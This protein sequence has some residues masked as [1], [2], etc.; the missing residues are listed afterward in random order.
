MLPDHSTLSASCRSL[1]FPH[2]G[3]SYLERVHSAETSRSCNWKIRFWNS[4]SLVLRAC[5]FVSMCCRCLIPCVRFVRRTGGSAT[6]FY[7]RNLFLLVLAASAWPNGHGPNSIYSY[8]WWSS[9]RADNPP[10]TLKLTDDAPTRTLFLLFA[11]T[12][13]RQATQRL[14][15]HHPTSKRSPS[16]QFLVLKTDE[17]ASRQVLS[18]MWPN[19]GRGAVTQ[20][21]GREILGFEQDDLHQTHCA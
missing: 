21:Y 10:A 8:G 2:R 13:G 14:V 16:M 1:S 19:P 7:C 18:S 6:T 15:V 12:S 11:V 4:D 3:N 5:V 17:R 9:R 20:N